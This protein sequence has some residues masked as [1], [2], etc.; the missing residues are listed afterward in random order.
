M[1]Y[2]RRPL[3]IFDDYFSYDVSSDT[4]FIE[5]HWREGLILQREGV[6][7]A[8][9]CSRHQA[10]IYSALVVLGIDGM[11]RLCKNVPVGVCC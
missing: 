7:M 8:E 4:A 6:F 9:E 5:K 3:T 1:I 2:R 10:I 11:Q